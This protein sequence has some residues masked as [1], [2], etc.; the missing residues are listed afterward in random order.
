M[1][2]RRCNGSLLGLR[3]MITIRHIFFALTFIT[4]TLVFWLVFPITSSSPTPCSESSVYSSACVSGAVLKGSS[5]VFQ[6]YWKTNEFGLLGSPVTV[7]DASDYCGV[8]PGP[9][10]LLP[11]EHIY[12]FFTSSGFEWRLC[13]DCE[14]SQAKTRGMSGGSATAED[15]YYFHGA[16]NNCSNLLNYE[17]EI[18]QRVLSLS[19]NW[20]SQQSVVQATK[21]IDLTDPDLAAMEH[22]CDENG[23]ISVDDNDFNR[24]CQSTTD[25]YA[26]LFSVS[27]PVDAYSAF[28][29]TFSLSC[30]DQSI[31]VFSTLVI[32]VSFL[33]TIITF[34]RLHSVHRFFRWV[35]R[36]PYEDE[37]DQIRKQLSRRNSQADFRSQVQMESLDQRE[38]RDL[39]HEF[40]RYQG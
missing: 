35:T 1:S 18:K 29:S 40:D 3:F 34:S 9:L 12:I 30:T 4:I 14:M 23:I 10:T 25:M 27:S 31:N 16:N 2:W 33:S 22:P 5:F 32:N 15:I 24:F 17:D 28:C 19:S 36:D 20:A 7:E 6:G 21:K 38:L 8:T 39:D 11:T 26:T 13:Q 37:I